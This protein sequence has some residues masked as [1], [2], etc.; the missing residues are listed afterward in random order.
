MIFYYLDDILG[1]H[2]EESIA[3]K[4][5]Y[6]SEKILK[7]LSLETKQSKAKPPSQ[8]QQWLGKVYDTK[9]QWLSLPKEKVD[10]YVHDIK[11]AMNRPSITKRHLL[12]HIGRTRHMASIYR[13]LSAFSR[14]LERW[15]YAKPIHLDHHIRMSRPLKNDLKLCIWA[16]RRAAE[17]G[18]SFNQFL[19]PWQIA[20]ISVY[21]CII[22]YWRRRISDKGHCPN[23]WNQIKLHNKKQ[24][25][26]LERTILS[27]SSL[28]FERPNKQST[29]LQITSLVNIC[30]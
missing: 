23:Y 19:K 14:N 13:T 2:E 15:A 1:G 22:T 7:K 5:F 20:D 26:G 11:I 3:W 21:R 29:Y 12:K 27:T 24:R 4:Q 30:L 25:H 28:T 17:Y 18:I 10:K 6:H 16:I 9:R 8:E